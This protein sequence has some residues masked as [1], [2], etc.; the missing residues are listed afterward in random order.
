M[1]ETETLQDMIAYCNERIAETNETDG[2]YTKIKHDLED[3]KNRL[4]KQT[5]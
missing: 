5:T 2:Y 4:Q 1:T 3:E